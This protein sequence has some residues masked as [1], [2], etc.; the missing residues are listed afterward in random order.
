M[1]YTKVSGANDQDFFTRTAA[2]DR[3]LLRVFI[4]GTNEHSVV[5]DTAAAAVPCINTRSIVGS[6]TCALDVFYDRGSTFP[7]KVFLGDGGSLCEELQIFRVNL[8][9][10]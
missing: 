1:K 4:Y 9:L 7:L 10:S 8:Y 5:V 6:S 3:L 2:T